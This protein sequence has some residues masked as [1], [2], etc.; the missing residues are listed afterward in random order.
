[1]TQPA[2]KNPRPTRHDP[3]LGQWQAVVTWRVPATPNVTVT[4][5]RDAIERFLQ[6]E[7]PGRDDPAALYVTVYEITAPSE[8]EGRYDHPAALA[9]LDDVQHVRATEDVEGRGRL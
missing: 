7:L 6:R 5:Y 1:M 4:A 2:P 9:N 8:D 3:T